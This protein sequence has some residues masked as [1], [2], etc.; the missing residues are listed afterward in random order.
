MCRLRQEK[1]GIDQYPLSLR[2]LFSVRAAVR[3][4][5]LTVG[6][7]LLIGAKTAFLSAQTPQ[8]QTGPVDVQKP[9]EQLIE[10][11]R[12]LEQQNLQLME[13]NRQLMDQIKSIRPS[14]ANQDGSVQITP[15]QN[16]PTASQLQPAGTSSQAAGQTNG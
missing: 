1:I 16:T 15:A 6:F 14:V 9:I 3:S 5:F 7:V 12:K 2:V 11:N 8:A 4:N 13:Q 10:Q